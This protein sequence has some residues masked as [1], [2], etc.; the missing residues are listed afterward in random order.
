MKRLTPNI[1]TD[2]D[3][4]ISMPMWVR[5]PRLSFKLLGN[6]AISELVSTIGIPIKTDEAMK[7]KARISFARVL[8]EVNASLGLPKMIERVDEDGVIF[9][10]EVIYENPPPTCSKCLCFRHVAEE[11]PLI[12]V[13]VPKAAQGQLKLKIRKMSILR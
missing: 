6:K 1:K 9:T 2:R 3:L 12:K 4:L 7:N 10:Q 5:L 8:V 11:C 13:L